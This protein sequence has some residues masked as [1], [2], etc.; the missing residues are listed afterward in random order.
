MVSEGTGEDG[1]TTMAKAATDIHEDLSRRFRVAYSVAL[2]GGVIMTLLSTLLLVND[3]QRLRGHLVDPTDPIADNMVQGAWIRGSIVVALLLLLWWFVLRPMAE[4]LSAER[5][6]LLEA[7][8]AQQQVSARQELATQLHEALDMAEDEA[9]VHGVVSRSLANIAPD[10]PSELLLADS[11][12]AHLALVAANPVAGAA[13]CGVS[14]PA[15]CPAVRRGRTTVFA[16]SS[17]LNACPHLVDRPGGACSAVC[18]PVSSMGRNL[19]VLHLTGPD[20]APPTME[21]TEGLSVVATQAGARIDNLRSVARMQLQAATDGLT[22]LA[23]RRATA[24][25]VS[26]LLRGGDSVVAV[27]MVDL[28]RFKHLNDT[29]GH[30]AGD[31]ALRAFAEVARRSLRDHDVIGRWGGEEFVIALPGLDRHQ[32]A[33]VLD[34]I[35]GALADQTERANLPPFTASFGVID[36]EVANDLDLAVR[37][38][39]EA[40]LAAK[41]QGRDRVVIG[42]VVVDPS[43]PSG[44][45]SRTG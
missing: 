20:G 12:R 25:L 26:R 11:S 36:S 8:A 35:R 39:D 21:R 3:V 40:L 15:K 33:V 19:G 4:N 6:R 27:A 37:L 43:L 31:R 2:T 7:E 5:R 22:G 10:L 34:R 17:A 32:A 38:A 41:T 18:I 9:A 30:D 45:A 1:G 16:S 13:G 28:D 23:N 29:F 14:S 42:P 24:E 44:T